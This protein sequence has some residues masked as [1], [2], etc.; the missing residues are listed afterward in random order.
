MKTI[1]H[2]FISLIVAAWVSAIAIFSVQNATPVSLNFL[3]FQSI[4]IPVGLVLALSATAG[5]IGG[6]IIKSLWSVPH[7]TVVSPLSEASRENR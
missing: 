4:K 2:L 1:P 7:T 3:F 5:I 6:A